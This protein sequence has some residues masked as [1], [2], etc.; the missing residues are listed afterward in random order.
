MPPESRKRKLARHWSE[1]SWDNVQC[2]LCPHQCSVAPS[3]SGACG[4][5]S[6]RDGKFYVDTYGRITLREVVGGFQIPLFHFQPGLRW[7]KVGTKGCTMRC[8]F[9]NTYEYSQLGAKNT[10]PVTPEEVVELACMEECGG[11]VFGCNEPVVSHEFLIDVFRVARKTGLK[12]A[13]Q[14]NGT[15]LEDPFQEVLILTDAFCFGI[16]GFNSEEYSNNFGAQLECILQNIET[17]V[18]QNHHVEISY[19]VTTPEPDLAREEFQNFLQWLT[20]LDTS[21][22]V[23]LSGLTPGY[24]SKVDVPQSLVESLH[25]DF[26]GQIQHLYNADAGSYQ[27]NSTFCSHCGEEVITRTTSG[28]AVHLNERKCCPSCGGA[29]SGFVWK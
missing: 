11:L 15:W 14:T 3:R 6:N 18:F 21:I 16:K 1:T 22:P 9:C 25:T 12:T 10:L 27:V 20:K 26:V 7:Y 5:R 28:T 4:V 19:L 2:N 23:I 8:P 17:A 24:L 13:L 29:V